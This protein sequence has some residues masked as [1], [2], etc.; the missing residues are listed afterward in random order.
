MR[1][2]RDRLWG[3]EADYEL[4]RGGEVGSGGATEVSAGRTRDGVRALLTALVREYPG[5]RAILE[6]LMQRRL[7]WAD[8][9]VVENAARLIASGHFA[10]WELRHRR[11]VAARPPQRP[12]EPPRAPDRE[13]R[14][15]TWIDVGVVDQFGRPLPWMQA[16]LTLP[17]G[18]REARALD[19]QG[20]TH[21]DELEVGGLCGFEVRAPGGATRDG[22]IE[23]PV[24]VSEPTWV[25]IKVVD[26]FGRPVPWLNARSKTAAGSV[27]ERA[28]DDDGRARLYPLDNAETCA[29][30][31]V[32]R[33]TRVEVAP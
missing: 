11:G 23:A 19:S 31:I 20:R 25:G 27:V 8:E 24:S 9:D 15:K 33:G 29:V 18:R 5:N 13:L 16:W 1:S 12:V 32:G 2:T 10:L 14:E 21:A 4:R 17:D 22:G 3:R 30:E 28:L 7:A 26:Q 6:A